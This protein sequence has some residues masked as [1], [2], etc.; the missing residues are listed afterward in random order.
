MASEAVL[1]SRIRDL[2]R[3]LDDLSA[4]Q[5]ED[6]ARMERETNARIRSLQEELQRALA[7]NKRRMDAEYSAVISRLRDELDREKESF[8]EELR[9]ASEKEAAERRA[10]MA[11]LEEA[12]AELRRRFEQLKNEEH[13]RSALGREMAEERSAAADGQAA[14]VELLP[15]GFFFPEELEAY[16]QHL[17]FSRD[18]IRS[19]MY[20]A[21][22]AAADAAL[23]E[24]QIF[25]IQVRQAQEEWVRLY[26]LYAMLAQS[27]HDAVIGFESAPIATAAGPVSLTD[28]ER[29]YFSGGRYPEIRGKV[30]E[31]YGLVR[32]MEASGGDPAVCLREADVPAPKGND[33]LL[34]LTGLRNLSDRLSSAIIFIENELRFSI[35]RRT[36][37]GMAAEAMEELGYRTVSEGFRGDDLME[38]YDVVLTINGMD[39]LQVTLAPVRRDG[40]AVGT[41]CI[42]SADV[43]TNPETKHVEG[44]CDDA[45]NCLE[46]AFEAQAQRE[47]RKNDVSVSRFTS[48]AEAKLTEGA[49]KAKPD[50]GALIAVRERKNG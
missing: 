48:P 10:L 4:R 42:V 50:L 1:Q 44:L 21:A 3:R 43:V 33:F 23:S 15:H 49:R 16:R 14:A 30:E 2:N 7:E 35:I 32:R 13:R 38:S 45:R 20:E 9:R 39:K 40:V 27:M 46:G 36:Y 11:E 37:G 41:V 17:V 34:Q 5:A 12:N 8:V 25:E 26:E 28:G 47:E 22:L 24:L 31:A 6:R 19:G 18:L 29:S